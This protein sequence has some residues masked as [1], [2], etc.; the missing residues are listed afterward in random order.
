LSIAQNDFAE[1]KEVSIFFLRY[2]LG[3]LPLGAPRYKNLHCLMINLSINKKNM[4]YG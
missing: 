4:T 3:P 2:A 1:M